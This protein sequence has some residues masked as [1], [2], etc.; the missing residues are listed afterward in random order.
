MRDRDWLF[1]AGVLFFFTGVV[2]VGIGNNWAACALL[3]ASL[4]AFW[5]GREEPP[6]TGGAVICGRMF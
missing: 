6:S 2:M 4:L 1:C 3:G 5:A